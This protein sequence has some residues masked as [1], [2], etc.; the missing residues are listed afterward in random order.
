MSVAIDGSLQHVSRRRGGS[1]L[2]SVSRIA[3]RTRQNASHHDP[4]L[5]NTVGHHYASL[6][7]TCRVIANR[8][9]L[10][11]KTKSFSP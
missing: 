5:T 6:L 2:P 11:P 7:P 3:L 10:G 9:H 4:R 8:R 1:P